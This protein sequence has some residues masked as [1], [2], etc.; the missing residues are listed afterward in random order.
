MESKTKEGNLQ[1]LPPGNPRPE[2]MR[3]SFLEQAE[4]PSVIGMVSG[5]SDKGSL[6]LL[7]LQ[8]MGIGHTFLKEGT[9]RYK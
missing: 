6:D 5:V 7:F 4:H 8:Q 9:H 2:P 1:K 3:P